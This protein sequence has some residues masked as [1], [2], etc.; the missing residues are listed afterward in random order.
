MPSLVRARGGSTLTSSPRNSIVPELGAVSPEMTLNS[1]VLPAP[2]GPRMARL[3]PCATSRSTP[4]TASRPPKRRPTPRKRRLGA[5]PPVTAASVNLLPDDLRDDL[6]AL[7]RKLPLRARGEVAARR[8]RLRREGAAEGLVHVGDLADGLD[9]QL[10]TLQ[11]ELLV[12][13]VRHRVAVL[14]ELD[15]PVRRVQHHLREGGLQLLLTT[16][17]VPAH[18]LEALDQREGVRVVAVR[19]DR[20]LLPGTRAERRDLLERLGEERVPRPG[21]RGGEG[22]RRARAAD[23]GARNAVAELLELAPRPPEEV[24]DELLPVDRP[25]RLLVGLEERDQ[26]GAADAD[27]GAVDVRRELLCEGRVVRR[28]ERCEDAFR[29]LAA[30]PAEVGDEAGRGRPCEGVVVGD[31]RRGLPVQLL[32]GEV[33]E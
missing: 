3:S 10:P 21:R 4:A 7:P 2:F 9:G 18:G 16:R 6:L 5:A 17:D 33:A 26:P 15:R 28:V 31:D 24:A 14:V 25:V 11:V 32:G 20:R 30:R 29:H 22:A 12:V 23:V 13:H 27:E 19:E 8:R 1:V